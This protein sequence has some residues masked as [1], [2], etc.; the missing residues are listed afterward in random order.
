MNRSNSTIVIAAFLLVLLAGAGM[1]S[2]AGLRV[3]RIKG[4]VVDVNKARVVN[5]VVIV[6]GGDV[7]RRAVSNDE[8]R[9]EFSLPPGSYQITAKADGFRQF[10]SP[11]LRVEPGKSRAFDVHL[12]VEPPVGL[13]PAVIQPQGCQ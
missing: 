2:P 1:T 8:G 9:F 7:K 5:A 10:T 6:Q 12:I 3:G 11:L 13:L 4:I